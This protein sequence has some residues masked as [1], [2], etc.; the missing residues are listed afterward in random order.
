MFALWVCNKIKIMS[1][2]DLNDVTFVIPFYKDSEER[3]ENL[4]CILKYINDNFETNISISEVGE[5]SVW[6]E[7]DV[8][9]CH[10]FEFRTD[11]L[12]HRTKVINDGIKH[13]S[14]RTPYIAIYD[15]DVIFNPKAIEIAANYLRLGFHFSYPYTGEFVDIERSYILD[16]VIREKESLTKDSCGG[17]VFINREAYWMAG[18]ENENIVSWGPEDICRKYRMLALGYKMGRSSGSC[19]H[20]KHPPSPNSGPNKYTS[21]NNEEYLK[22]SNMSKDELQKYIKTWEWLRK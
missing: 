3:L 15:T 16:G 1:K 7:L 14:V 5:S 21:K 12:F 11:G 2:I 6:A 13:P 8:S 17:A 18:L 19:Y 10:T 4:K 9:G 22:I 20:I